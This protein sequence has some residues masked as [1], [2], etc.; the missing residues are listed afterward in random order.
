M[1]LSWYSLQHL[2]TSEIQTI[3]R[4]L[5]VCIKV[6]GNRRGVR[7]HAK[8]SYC[9]QSQLFFTYIPTGYTGKT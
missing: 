5:I 7:L 3:H 9:L 8:G 6:V 4:E 1:Y 2:A